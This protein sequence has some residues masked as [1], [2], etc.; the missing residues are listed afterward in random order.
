MKMT[1][2]LKKGKIVLEAEVWVNE[3]HDVEKYLHQI[4][5]SLYNDFSCV[6]HDSYPDAVVGSKIEINKW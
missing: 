5:D 2:K 4:I 6:V 3:N 1:D